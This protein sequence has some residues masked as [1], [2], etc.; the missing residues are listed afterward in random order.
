MKQKG[1]VLISAMMTWFASALLTMLDPDSREPVGTGHHEINTGSWLFYRLE[2]E[3]RTS[4]EPEE[5]LGP[6]QE[7]DVEGA[8]KGTGRETADAL[9]EEAAGR[10]AAERAAA[11]RRAEEIARER[12]DSEREAKEREAAGVLADLDPDED[13]R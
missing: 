10:Q 7:M 4:V 11:E 2:Q 8:D 12:A 3:E 6:R 1:S 13:L 5:D 9:H